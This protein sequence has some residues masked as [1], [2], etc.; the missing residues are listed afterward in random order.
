MRGKRAKQ[1]EID[2]DPKYG[3]IKLSKFINYLMVGGK[4]N[5]ARSAV[6]NSLDKLSSEL[7]GGN[8]VELFEKALLNVKPPIEIK[9][10]R[11]GGANY[12]VPVPVDEKRQEAL[13]MK[14]IIEAARSHRG[15]KPFEEALTAELLNAT[16]KQGDAI[17]KKEETVRMA[18]ANKAFAHFAF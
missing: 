2:A 13:A 4:K 16:N 5:I 12:Q 18:E 8:P 11:V 17:K 1:R 6:Y 3:S 9:A 15:N 10:R 14:W 7:K